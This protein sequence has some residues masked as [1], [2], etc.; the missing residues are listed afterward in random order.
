MRVLF[1]QPAHEGHHF[2]YLA[3]MMPGFVELPIEIV[4]ATTRA[5]LASVEFEKTLAPFGSRLEMLDCCTP[6]PR[7]PL[8]NV[9]H[10][11]RELKEAIRIAKPDHVAV[12]YADGIWDLACLSA[13]VGRRPWPRQLVVEGWLYRGRFADDDDARAKSRLRRLIFV[14]LLR[15]GLFRKLH[16][17]HELLYKFAAAASDGTPTSVVLAPDPIV[18]RE[19]LS[20]AQARGELGITDNRDATHWIGVAGV[21][22]RFKGAHLLLD[23]FRI[24]RE[25]A[26]KPRVRLLLAGPHHKDIRALLQESPYR[27]AVAAGDIVSVDRYL[28]EHEMYSA[29]A[30]VDLVVAPYPQHQNRSSI[31][32]W[33]AAAGRPCLGANDSCVG[34]VIREER[35]GGTCNVQKTTDLADAITAMLSTPWTADDAARVRSYATFHRMENYQAISSQLVRERLEVAHAGA[36]TAAEVK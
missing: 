30:A 35:L 7:K 16:L 33:A 23:A 25:R 27:D 36:A 2:G 22:A 3:R 19:P 8:A 31:I 15:M 9:R 5:A 6:A 28:T 29:A 10:R 11:L 21:I 17:H 26:A 14:R 1:Y 12:C 32:L 34:Y 20:P 24:R 4:V 18:I 13:A